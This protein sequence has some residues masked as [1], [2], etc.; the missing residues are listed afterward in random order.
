MRSDFETVLRT[1][2]RSSDRQ[3]I[4]AAHGAVLSDP[5]L[6]FQITDI[7]KLRVVEGRVLLHA[8]DESSGRRYLLL[9][10]TDAKVHLIYHTDSIE[11]ARRAGRL[12]VNSFVRLEKR[13]AERTPH[14]EISDHGD[15]NALFENHVFFKKHAQ[16]LGSPVGWFWRI[17]DPLPRTAIWTR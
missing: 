7:R 16:I 8:E 17:S 9:E 13:F 11:E 14:I 2:Q 3:K 6:P 1:L 10:G 4:L 12:A 5:R 15:A